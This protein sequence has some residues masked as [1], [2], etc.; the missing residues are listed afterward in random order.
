M[1][2][3]SEYFPYYPFDVHEHPMKQIISGHISVPYAINVNT[4]T[5]SVDFRLQKLEGKSKT[6]KIYVTS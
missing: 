4:Y 5:G 6:T 1:Q 3:N 2:E